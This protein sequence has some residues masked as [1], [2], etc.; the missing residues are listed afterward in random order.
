MQFTIIFFRQQ[1]RRTQKAGE[2]KEAGGPKIPKRAEQRREEGEAQ[3][4][5]EEGEGEHIEPQLALSDAQREG[6][7]RGGEKEA[8]ERVEQVG[9]GASAAAAQ[10]QGAQT[11][12]E[13]G[14]GRAEQERAPEGA[15]LG[16]E[17]NAH[18]SAPEQTA[19]KTA[20][21]A[22]GVLIE[23]RVDVAV[24]MKLAAVEAELAEVQALAGDDER[25]G[26]GGHDDLVFV[27]AVDIVHS[28]DDQSLAAVQLNAMGGGSGGKGVVGHNGTSCKKMISHT[29]KCMGGVSV[30]CLL[31][32][33]GSS[34]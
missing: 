12:I 5:A 4:R 34:R 28:G 23:K 7:E 16:A 29:P 2:G 24:D 22:A 8:V 3:D 1:E 9:Q 14:E 27:K 20:G 33:F 19:Q 30:I 31:Y 13:Q 17:V 11:V 26:G 25:A 6:D 10:A 21:G 15:E 18:A 32:V